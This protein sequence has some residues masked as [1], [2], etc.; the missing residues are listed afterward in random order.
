LPNGQ[1]N[2]HLYQSEHP[3]GILMKPC[4]VCGYKY[5]TAWN[6][7]ELPEEVIEF[8]QSLPDTPIKPA[9]I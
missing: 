7:E 1:W 4:P 5:G 3:E 8:L 6:K 2:S 9:W